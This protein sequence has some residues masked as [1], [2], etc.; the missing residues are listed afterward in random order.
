MRLPERAVVSYRTLGGIRFPHGP[1]LEQAGSPTAGRCP[2][3]DHLR[4]DR[5]LAVGRDE[6]T[7]LK[8]VERV[9]EYPGV[10]GDKLVQR[11]YHHEIGS[12]HEPGS[13][14]R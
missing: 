10:V 3:G 12:P 5:I 9:V 7:V 6:T 8:E 13:W 14:P 11:R 4:L 2:S 1:V